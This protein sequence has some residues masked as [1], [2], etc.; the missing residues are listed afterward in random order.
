MVWKRIPTNPPTEN[1]GGVR[2]LPNRAHIEHPEVLSVAVFE[3]LLG[4]FSAVSVEAFDAC[5]GI[6]HYDY[7]VR[8][9]YKI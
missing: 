2:V 5:S 6:A 7:M 4:V 1:T 3:E 9:I 8:Q